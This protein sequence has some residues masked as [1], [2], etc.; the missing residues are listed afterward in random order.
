MTKIRLE[1]T[2]CKSSSRENQKGILIN[3]TWIHSGESE[4][5]LAIM[6]PL[7]ESELE[8]PLKHDKASAGW[9]TIRVR[10]EQNPKDE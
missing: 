4:L 2:S 5:N 6:N 8:V 3:T 7:R 1:M 10:F 9:L